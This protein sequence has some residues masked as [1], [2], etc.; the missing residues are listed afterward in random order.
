MYTCAQ[1][2]DDADMFGAAAPV[3]AP[4]PAGNQY[5]VEGTLMQDALVRM[6]ASTYGHAAPVLCVTLSI[7]SG[8]VTIHAEQRYPSTEHGR[9]QADLAALRLRKGTRVQV[10]ASPLDM[11]VSLPHAVS[12]TP[13]ASSP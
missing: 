2:P 8:L 6:A 7:A 1:S 13:L 5:Q 3:P 4:A 11:R 9:V 10:L 12:I